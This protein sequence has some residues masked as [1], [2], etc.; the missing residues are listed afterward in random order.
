VQTYPHPNR[1]VRPVLSFARSCE[2]IRRAR[3]RE[4]EGVSLRIHLD[5]AVTGE[6]L[7]QRLPM[8]PQHI[9]VLLAQLAQQ[10]GRP[11]DVREQE[12]DRAGG[13]VAHGSMMRPPAEDVQPA[14]RGSTS[15][16][17]AASS[18]VPLRHDAWTRIRELPRP[19]AHF[20]F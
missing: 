18:M 19:V 16:S 11:L 3:K 20:A 9:G 6:C 2:R 1:T 14:T 5:A 12:G 4:E 15:N 17:S 10:P 8:L 7:A 13:E